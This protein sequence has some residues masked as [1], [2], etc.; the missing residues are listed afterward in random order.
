MRYSQLSL[1]G[2]LLLLTPQTESFFLP[3]VVG[4]TSSRQNRELKCT[5]VSFSFLFCSLSQHT[6][7]S[8]RRMCSYSSSFRSLG[9]ML[10]EL[11]VEKGKVPFSDQSLEAVKMSLLAGMLPGNLS[12]AKQSMERRVQ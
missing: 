2:F 4:S 10:V 6:L 3:H 1:E 9:I 8:T 5:V 12:E 11:L 7:S